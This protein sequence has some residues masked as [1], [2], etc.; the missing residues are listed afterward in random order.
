M[1]KLKQKNYQEA[2]SRIEE[3]VLNLENEEIEMDELSAQV[4][5][6]IELIQFCKTKLKSTSEELNEA[7]KKLEEE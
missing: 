4:K 6:A 3:I 5:E 1:K 7:L 2:M